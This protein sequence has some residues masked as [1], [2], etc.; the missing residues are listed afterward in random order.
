MPTFENAQKLL[1]LGAEVHYGDISNHESCV[2]L[3]KG[4]EN[5][6]VIHAAGLIHPKLFTKEFVHFNLIGQIKL[7]M[8][9]SN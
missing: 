2:D 6:L 9:T 3:L 7:Y 4:E 5:S 1:E 8:G